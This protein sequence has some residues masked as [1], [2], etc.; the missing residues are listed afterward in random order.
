MEPFAIAYSRQDECVVRH[1]HGDGGP[2]PAFG[3]A[4]RSRLRIILTRARSERREST[5]STSRALSVEGDRFAARR[6]GGG[7]DDRPP[8]EFEAQALSRYADPA[9]PAAPGSHPWIIRKPTNPAC[10]RPSPAH[11]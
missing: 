6:C 2:R 8:A 4:G 10:V 9:T 7:L 11:W 1:R 5:R 3:V